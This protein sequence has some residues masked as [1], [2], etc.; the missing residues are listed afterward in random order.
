M[1]RIFKL[2]HRSPRSNLS[3]RL[4]PSANWP[5][6]AVESRAKLL[7]FFFPA[8]QVDIETVRLI[9]PGPGRSSSFRQHGLSCLSRERNTPCSVLRLQC[10]KHK[11]ERP[12][13]GLG[14]IIRGLCCP[15][16]QCVEAMLCYPLGTWKSLL[17]SRG[18][19]S[20][21]EEGNDQVVRSKFQ[22]RDP[23][24]FFFPFSL[25][26]IESQ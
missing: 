18:G 16:C 2:S 10:P 17:D 1:K 20:G 25:V 23:W 9:G 5:H 19:F 3:N 14:T 21:N 8:A 6:Q 7:I 4:E 26:Q 24:Q 15:T 22:H 12:V 11:W 13:K